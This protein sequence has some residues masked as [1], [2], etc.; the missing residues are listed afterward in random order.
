[1][2]VYFFFT[3]SYVIC[4]TQNKDQGKEKLFCVFFQKELQ[5]LLNQKASNEKVLQV[6]LSR[7][8]SCRSFFK[9][10]F[11]SHIFQYLF[12]SRG[13][14]MLATQTTGLAA[15]ASLVSITKNAITS[16]AQSFRTTKPIEVRTKHCQAI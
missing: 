9:K 2:S 6:F 4:G 3:K 16:Q 14:A 5:N 10:I 1:M 13:Q 7:L 15:I 11:L 8:K 12:S